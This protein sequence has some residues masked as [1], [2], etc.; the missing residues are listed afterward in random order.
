[1][2]TDLSSTCDRSTVSKEVPHSNEVNEVN[3]MQSSQ[4]E[5]PQSN[6]DDVPAA[7]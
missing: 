6:E 1:M 2:K 3:E 4:P 5:V 7:E